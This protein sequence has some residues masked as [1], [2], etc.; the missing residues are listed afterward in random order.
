MARRSIADRMMQYARPTLLRGFAPPPVAVAPD[1]WTLER[2]LRMPGG[3]VLSSRTSLIRLP[4]GGLLV[5]SPPPLGAGGLDALDALG[6]VEEILVPNSFHYLYAADFAARYPRAMLRLAPALRERVPDVP[7]EELGADTPA[8]WRPA[9]EQ[10]V[11]GPVRG[12][13]E[14]ALFHHPSATLVLSDL[15]F[16][17]VHFE[18]AAQRLL[19]RFSGVPVGFGPSRTARM[20]LLGDRAAVQAFLARVVAWPIGRIVVAHG[21]PLETD[22]AA[23]LRRAFAAYL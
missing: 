19:W 17:M 10:Q 13:S 2:R 20:L 14:V 4:S 15:A 23:A 8:S 18:S 9:V 22:A 1:L 16:N 5:V 21:E 3:P 12:L 11:L 7:G 6:A